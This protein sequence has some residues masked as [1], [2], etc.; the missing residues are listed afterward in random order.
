MYLSLMNENASRNT[1][2]YVYE[3]QQ[4]LRH[5]NVPVGTEYAMVSAC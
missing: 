5:E 2:A 3:I 1:P 4:L